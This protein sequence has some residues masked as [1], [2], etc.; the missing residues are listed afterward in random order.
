MRQ[1]SF[2]N[3]MNKDLSFFTNNTA[4][5][6]L[7]RNVS[8][9]YDSTEG[10]RKMTTEVFDTI[11]LLIGYIISLFVMD[12]KLTLMVCPFIILSV[13]AAHFMKKS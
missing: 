6:I 2:E 10:I 1:V 11:V 9:I 12:Y 13:L 4:G 8:D 7:N 5:D 3:L